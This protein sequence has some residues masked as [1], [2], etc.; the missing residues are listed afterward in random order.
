MRYLDNPDLKLTKGHRYPDTWAKAKSFFFGFTGEL[1]DDVSDN[2]C[3]QKLIEW[4]KK[5]C[6]PPLFGERGR[7]ND[8]ENIWR[9]VERL[10]TGK[11]EEERDKRADKQKQAEE[12]AKK[13]YP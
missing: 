4:H 12:E 11:R 5:V 8:V 13:L 7:E 3:Y 10:F 9:N 6:D 1:T 2:I